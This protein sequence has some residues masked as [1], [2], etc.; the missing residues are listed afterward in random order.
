[1]RKVIRQGYVIEVEQWVTNVRS[2]G[3]L[4]WTIRRD[5]ALAEALRCWRIYDTGQEIDELVPVQKDWNTRHLS[6]HFLQDMEI[7]ALEMGVI[8]GGQRIVLH[9]K[10]KKKPVQRVVLPELQ[11]R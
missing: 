4:Y 3:I 6:E 11:Q 7:G 10:R 2:C 1:M 8:E 5:A 9:P